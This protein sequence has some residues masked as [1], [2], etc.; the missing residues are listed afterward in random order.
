ME[1]YPFRSLLDAGVPL[2][3]GSDFPGESFFDPI[4]GI[5]L[6]V[7]REGPERITAAEALACYTLGSAYAEFRE[8][9]KGSI[10]PGKLADFAVLSDSIVDVPE[11]EII[12][13]RVVETIVGGKTVFKREEAE[14][15]RRDSNGQAAKAR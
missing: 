7:N 15:S 1:A 8:N 5:H 6:A 2:S 10:T 13:L 12:N 11:E 3:F 4:R 9:E 14:S